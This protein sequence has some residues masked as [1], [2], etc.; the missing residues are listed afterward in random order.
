MDKKLST[1]KPSRNDDMRKS[2]NKAKY[3]N[4]PNRDKVVPRGPLPHPESMLP[5]KDVVT[6]K[7]QTS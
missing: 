5:K 7:E 6:D 1:A 2:N 4:V 3:S